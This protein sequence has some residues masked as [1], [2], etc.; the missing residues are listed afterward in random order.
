MM[1]SG[2]SVQ[3]YNAN[4]LNTAVASKMLMRIGVSNSEYQNDTRSQHV[5]NPAGIISFFM[6]FP[7]WRGIVLWEVEKYTWYRAE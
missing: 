5:R 2:L 4:Q 3:V 6:G 1:L 7:L